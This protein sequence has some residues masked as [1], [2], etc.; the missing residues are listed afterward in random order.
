MTNKEENIFDKFYFS[1]TLDL[2]TAFWVF[3]VFG[4]TVENEIASVYCASSHHGC[5][6]SASS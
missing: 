4:E 5:L 6:F 1:N 2:A 3:G